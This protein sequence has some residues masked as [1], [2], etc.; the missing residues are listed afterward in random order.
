MD[1]PSGETVISGM[2]PSIEVTCLRS[3]PSPLT[4][5]MFP[6]PPALEIKK[7]LPSGIHKGDVSALLEPEVIGRAL[8]GS[9]AD[10]T[11]ILACRTDFMTA[12]VPESA[13]KLSAS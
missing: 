11:Q 5:Q 9:E 4:D 13:V 7:I 6:P 12:K 10:D 1:R 8:P 3:L 2:S